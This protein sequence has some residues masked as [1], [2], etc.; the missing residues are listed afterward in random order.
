MFWKKKK[1]E[2]EKVYEM[3]GKEAD[4]ILTVFYTAI[5]ERDRRT[6]DTAF[7]NEFWE[8]VGHTFGWH[9]GAFYMQNICNNQLIF[10]LKQH[11]KK[12]YNASLVPFTAK[13]LEEIT[14]SLKALEELD[15]I[16]KAIK[17]FDWDNFDWN[18]LK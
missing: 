7:W 16:K 10:E 4:G 12:Y 3:Y 18:K 13:D 6:N 2:I 1:S 14:E 17:D 5:C 11:G 15:P 8:R 9:C